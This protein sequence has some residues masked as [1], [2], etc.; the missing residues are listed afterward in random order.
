[1]TIIAQFARLIDEE[2]LCVF[3]INIWLKRHNSKRSPLC[4]SDGRWIY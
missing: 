3:F 4:L 1:M 2:I